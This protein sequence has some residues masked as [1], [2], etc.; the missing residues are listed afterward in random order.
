[1]FNNIKA[2]SAQTMS[3]ITKVK[4]VR[5]TREPYDIHGHKSSKQT[6][7]QNSS[8][9]GS[10]GTET[11]KSS[12]QSEDKISQPTSDPKH[13]KQSPAMDANEELKS[14]LLQ[15]KNQQVTKTDLQGYTDKINSRMEN[16]ETKIEKHE[17][18]FVIINNRLDKIEQN[19]KLA[20]YERELDKQ[21]QLRNNICIFGIPHKDN[22]NLTD[23]AVKTFTLIG[24]QMDSSKILSAY[25]INGNTNNIIVVKLSEYELKQ[26]LLNLKAV[27]VTT[28]GN[29]LD[30]ETELANKKIYLN[31][32]LTPFF[33]RILHHGRMA[34]K[35]GKLHSCWIYSFGCQIKF[36]TEGKTYGIRSITQLNDLL[37]EKHHEKNNK[38]RYAPS[39][40]TSPIEPNPKK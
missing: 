23:L 29:I 20:Q 3:K 25:R 17:D 28:I 4:K 6:L 12:I 9:S 5:N 35:A 13:N 14:L 11:G 2:L 38:K 36:S 33:G 7:Q 30:C 27:N 1:M 34:I 16:I 21:R 10:T 40:V 19:A 18:N 26:Q 24:V 37:N 31:N 22:E 8:S 39:D 32:H 15:I